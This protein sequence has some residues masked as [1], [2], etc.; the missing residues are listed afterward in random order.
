MKNFLYLLILTVSILPVVA[1]AQQSLQLFAISIPEFL[2]NV[3]VPFLFSIAFLVFV[4]NAVRYFVIDSNEEA[5]REKAR[6]LA[7]YGI[8]AFVFLVIFF[9]IVNI[10]IDTLGINPGPPPCPDYLQKEGGCGG[11][12]GGGNVPIPGN[13]PATPSGFGN[14]PIPGNKPAVP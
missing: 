12:G 5:G 4:V 1:F 7:T 11:A 9:G 8:V 6:A 13:K 10:F 2:F 3:L 14:P